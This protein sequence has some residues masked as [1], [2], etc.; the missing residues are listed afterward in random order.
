MIRTGG[1]LIGAAKAYKTAGASEIFT[2]STHGVFPPGAVERIQKSGLIKGLIVTDSHPNALHE[3]QEHPQFVSLVH[4][5]HIL[6]EAIQE[7]G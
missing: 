5:D 7:R 6:T 4:L 3:A 1:S 2:I